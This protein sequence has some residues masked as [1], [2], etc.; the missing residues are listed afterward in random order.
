MLVILILLTSASA[1]A[2]VTWTVSNNTVWGSCVMTGAVTGLTTL[3][4]T[5]IWG[6]AIFNSVSASTLRPSDNGISFYGTFASGTTYTS[7]SVA[8][9]HVDS[10]SKGWT[11]S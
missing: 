5:N 1:T 7:K 11:P 2:T 9:V 10:T 3:V 6:G 8:Y 4:A